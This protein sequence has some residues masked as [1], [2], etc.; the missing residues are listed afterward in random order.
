MVDSVKKEKEEIVKRR[1]E[2]LKEMNQ[3]GRNR[4][5]HKKVARKMP[6]GG[7]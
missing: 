3:R 1:E 4:F 7:Y 6:Y 2:K 5:M